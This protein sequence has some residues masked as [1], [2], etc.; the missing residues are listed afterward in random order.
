MRESY[1]LSLQFELLVNENFEVL[2]AENVHAAR[3]CAMP[4]YLII[5]NSAVRSLF[6]GAPLLEKLKR[7]KEN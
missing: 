4:R 1:S 6:S 2:P 5:E 3:R 7:M